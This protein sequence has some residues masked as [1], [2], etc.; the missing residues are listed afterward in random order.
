MTAVRFREVI[1]HPC[2]GAPTGGTFATFATLATFATSATFGPLATFATF[3]TGRP[4]TRTPA[5]WV[6]TDVCM[7][8]G[9]AK[10]DERWG[11]A[12]IAPCPDR[13][14]LSAT[15]TEALRLGG[16]RRQME[17]DCH[18]DSH[19]RADSVGQSR[20]AERVPGRRCG[21]RGMCWLARQ[22]TE[23]YRFCCKMLRKA[24]RSR[25][26]LGREA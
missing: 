10:T 11:H 2:R 15:R 13:T 18:I 20:T 7:R 12:L 9:T 3:G 26:M 24:G 17:G 14:S 1:A 19:S 25:T 4:R 16:L 5:Q 8:C 6:G 23:R 21:G 22:S